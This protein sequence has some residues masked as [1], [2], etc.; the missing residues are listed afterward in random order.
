VRKTT[1]ALIVIAS[2]M[3]AGC[4]SGQIAEADPAGD[5]AGESV[6]ASTTSPDTEEP[7]A[8]VSGD[9]VCGAYFT[10]LKADP[11]VV[12]YEQL[13][14]ASFAAPF[15]IAVPLPDCAV[16]LE[17][18]GA[19]V[20]FDLG[21]ENTDFAVVHDALLAG[22]LVDVTTWE[23]DTSRKFMMSHAD[24][25]GLFWLDSGEGINRDIPV[26]DV[27]FVYAE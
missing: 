17:Q 24:G 6:D 13:D 16:R 1:G 9:G 22:G 19:N 14:P 26:D 3:L 20:S 15:G 5:G 23:D 4:G 2:L 8:T 11:T 7:A 18:V 25:T 10:A 27:L 12:H 21:W